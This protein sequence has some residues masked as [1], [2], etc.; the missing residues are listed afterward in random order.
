MVPHA[1][2]DSDPFRAEGTRDTYRC[3]QSVRGQFRSEQ[4]VDMSNAHV[5]DLFTHLR[6]EHYGHQEIRAVRLAGAI[7]IVVGVVI[8]FAP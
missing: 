8:A 7:M 6:Q 1:I 5:T 4:S 3:I 2:R